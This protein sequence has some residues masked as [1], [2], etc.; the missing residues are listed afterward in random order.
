MYLWLVHGS[1]QLSLLFSEYKKVFHW[2]S[3]VQFAKLSFSTAWHTQNQLRQIASHLDPLLLP[4]LLNIEP[5]IYVRNHV[6]R[7][8]NVLEK[9]SMC[10]TLKHS[11]LPAF[12]QSIGFSVAYVVSCIIQKILLDL[13]SWLLKAADICFHPNILSKLPNRKFKTS[14]NFK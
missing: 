7:I 5:R 8:L 1:T 3:N 2:F 10:V 14:L 9:A 4:R 6:I 12:L 11:N 13:K